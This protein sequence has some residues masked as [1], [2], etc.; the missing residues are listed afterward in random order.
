MET[1]IIQE[2]SLIF[3]KAGCKGNTT[4]A[5]GCLY[6]LVQ[7]DPYYFNLI[8]NN[9]EIPADKLPQLQS[10]IRQCMYHCE[11]NNNDSMIP[12]PSTQ[13]PMMVPAWVIILIILGI[14][15]LVFF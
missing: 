4:K 3:K 7:N 9:L 10:Y 1:K 12:Q 15:I 5:A 2:L 13:I 8:S 11:G 6:K 14:I